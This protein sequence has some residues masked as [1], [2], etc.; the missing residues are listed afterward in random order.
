MTAPAAPPVTATATFCA[1]LVDEWVRAGVTAAMLAPGSRSTPLALAL[2]RQ[3]RLRVHLFHDERAAGYAAVGHGLTTGRPAVVLCTSGTAAT[4]LHGAV[5]EADLAAVPLIVCTA[6][7]PPE[8]WGVGAP[9]TI[10]QNGLYGSAVRG[11]HQPGVP[12]DGDSGWWRSLASRLVADAVGWAG[13]PG[14]VHANL[15]FRDPLVGSPGPLPPGRPGTAP[16]HRTE[17]GPRAATPAPG[18][19]ATVLLDTVVEPGTGR[20]RA[21]SGVFVVGRTTARSES[22]TELARRLGWPVLADHRSGCRGGDTAI[23]RFDGLLRSPSFAAAAVPDVI[24]RIGEP[25][26]SKLVSQ[27]IETAA[28]AG[29]EVISV[30]DR[31]RWIDP[32]RAASVVVDDPAGLDDL[33][34]ALPERLRPAAT[35]AWW[36]RADEAAGAA[37]ANRLPVEPAVMAAV[38][39]TLPPEAALVVASSMPVRDLEW[40]GPPGSGVAV[41]ANRGAN[42]IDGV[43]AT[44]IGVALTGRPT[45]VVVGDLAFLHDSTAL[46]ALA[47]RDVDLE[48]VVIDN[49]GGGIFSFL[50]QAALLDHERFEALFGTP[51]GTDV[52]ALAAAHRLPVTRWPDRTPGPGPRVVVASSDR[53]ANRAGHAALN[54]AIVAVADDHAA[55]NPR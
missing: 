30:T 39:D 11:F 13:R 6:D 1:T 28:A 51:H 54:A 37:G 4:H 47:A 52:A 15:S 38:V 41:L 25:L 2:T 7:R 9:Q 27:W 33:P 49:D 23:R 5:V 16:W 53:D 22:I 44:A 29:T 46:I 21:R 36:R 12:H 40:Y 35:A 24:V 18:G 43:V 32:E 34:A 55:S 17:P 19:A 50:A 45:T 26:A 20:G 14:P 31:G 10:D 3:S 8:L 42:G 48:I